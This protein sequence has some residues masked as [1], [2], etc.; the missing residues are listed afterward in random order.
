[1]LWMIGL[2]F[3]PQTPNPNLRG[4]DRGAARTEAGGE[5]ARTGS[6]LGL[7]DFVVGV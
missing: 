2:L 4:L 3:E 5:A 6:D 7:G 1:M